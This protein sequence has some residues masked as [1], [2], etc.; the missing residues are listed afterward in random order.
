MVKF[1]PRGPRS[2]WSKRN[3]DRALALIA[4][5]EMKPAGLAEVER[6]RKDSRWPR[7]G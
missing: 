7:S 3:R 1:T 6:A 5:G 4:A 2:P